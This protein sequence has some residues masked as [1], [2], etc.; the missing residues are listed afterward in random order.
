MLWDGDIIPLQHD[1]WREED[2]RFAL[3]TKPAQFAKLE[4]VIPHVPS[5]SRSTSHVCGMQIVHKAVIIELMNVV[6]E[7][8]SVG[9]F[10]PISFESDHL[11]V[12]FQTYGK[13]VQHYHPNLHSTIP[14]KQTQKA[15]STNGRQ[16]LSY[17]SNIE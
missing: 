4:R 17:G 12:E 14:L 5:Y 6:Q 1:R 7:W 10:Q 11:L 9:D 3:C 8:F 13:W 16:L 15:S 2:G